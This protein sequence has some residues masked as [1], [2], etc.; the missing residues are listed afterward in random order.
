MG[1]EGRRGRGES[2][3]AKYRVITQYNKEVAENRLYT[4]FWLLNQKKKKNTV[5]GVIAKIIIAC[6]IFEVLR[7]LA[8]QTLSRS[9]VMISPIVLVFFI[10]CLFAVSPKI[11]DKVYCK[12][13]FKT[14]VI[15]DL[16]EIFEYDFFDTKF[17]SKFSQGANE[18][19]YSLLT[20]LVETE[21]YF[22]LFESQQAAYSLKKSDFILGTPADFR[23]F[24]QAV[25][26]KRMLV[27]PTK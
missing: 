8:T 19:F 10:P 18:R 12:I 24:I 16:D 21:E 2:M 5:W 22:F 25:C 4:Y 14:T 27:K 1:V 17:I 26:G 9:L 3:E 20:D 7:G 6:M 23:D 11:R 13:I 15:K